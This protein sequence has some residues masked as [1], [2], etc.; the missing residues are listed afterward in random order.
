MSPRLNPGGQV[1]GPHNSTHACLVPPSLLRKNPKCRLDYPEN[2][3]GWV[4]FRVC[5]FVDFQFSTLSFF[6]LFHLSLV[7]S[8]MKVTS[9]STRWVWPDSVQFNLC[10]CLSPSLCAIFIATMYF[11]LIY[12]CLSLT[13]KVFLSKLNIWVKVGQDLRHYYLSPQEAFIRANSCDLVPVDGHFCPMEAT[14]TF[15]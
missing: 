2:P 5:D 9:L 13:I 3:A 11:A 14:K 12:N 8:T 15:G 4:I 7:L 1:Q 6:A 10:P